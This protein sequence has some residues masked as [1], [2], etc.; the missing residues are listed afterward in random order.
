MF[1]N[2]KVRLGLIVLLTLASVALLVTNY[3]RTDATGHRSGQIVNLGL[4][5]QGG[6]HYAMEIAESQSKLSAK[7]RADAID[8]ALKVVRMRVDELGVSEPVVQKAGSDRIIVELA[9]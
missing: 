3:N 1:Q 5:L 7:D 4:D 2:L 9:G 8:R 6:S